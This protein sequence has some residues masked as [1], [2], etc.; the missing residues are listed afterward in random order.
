MCM[1]CLACCCRVELKPTLQTLFDTVSGVCKQA[2][3]L[4]DGIPR[5]VQDVI[6]GCSSTYGT[7]RQGGCLVL[8]YPHAM[9][10]SARPA[11][12]A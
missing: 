10:A 12:A 9:L 11:P 4:M 8:A 5:V 3:A 6:Q 7:V 1:K 2:I